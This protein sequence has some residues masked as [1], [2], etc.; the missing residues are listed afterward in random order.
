MRT[1]IASILLF[2]L[3]A[4]TIAAP[5]ERSHDITPEDY[6]SV[7]LATEVAI[8]PDGKQVVYSLGTWDKKTDKRRSDLWVVDTD[9]KGKARQ[10]THENANYHSPK[11]SADRK[12]IYAIGTQKKEGLDKPPH[13]GK[14]QVWKIPVASG[15]PSAV[16]SLESGVEAFDYASKADAI[17]YSIETHATDED[18]FSALRKKFDRPDYSHG[19]RSASEI[20]RI[21]SGASAKK[22]VAEKRFIR[23]FSV[24]PDGK[25]IAMISAHDDTVVKSEGESRVDVWEDGKVVTPPTE[26]YR[27]DAASPYAWLESLVMSPDGNRFAFCAIFDGYPAEIIVGEW[28]SNEWDTHRMPRKEGIQVRGYG[29][30][31]RWIRAD[32]LVGLSDYQGTVGMLAYNP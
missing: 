10:L 24:S 17:F 32:S 27:K 29:C 3:I 28:K 8:S 18:D 6:A 5:P 19:K 25:R 23:E 9:G 16:T 1:A 13:N 7:N 14:P 11:W 12:F 31:L 2:A 26:V 30:P 4:P 22:V 15:E 21:D 20:H